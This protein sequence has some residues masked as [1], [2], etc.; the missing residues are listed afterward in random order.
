[1]TA[2]RVA[3]ERRSSALRSSARSRRRRRRETL[4]AGLFLSPALLI[5]GLFVVAPAVWAVYVSLT[6]YNLLGV[7]ANVHRFV[8]LANYRRLLD[9]P[10]FRGAIVRT[11]IFVF[12][13]AIVGQFVLG[14]AAA[15]IL[16][17]RD[18]RAR[19]LLGALIVLPLAVPEVVAGMMWA[20]ML[21][22]ERLGT[23]NRVLGVVGVGPIQWIANH[24]LLTIVVVN[25]W[26]GTA[27]AAI[28][29]GGALEAMPGD[30]VE[31]A[32]VDGATPRQL[33]RHVTVPLI[34]HAIT[35]YMLMTT[36]GTVTVFG[37]VF[38]L[39]QGGPGDQT[40]LLSI[41][42]YLKSFKF[43]EFG[44][45]AAASVLMFVLVLPLGAL[46]VRLLR[47]NV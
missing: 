20:S 29:F 8:G 14:L 25:I 43:F 47:A 27:F 2:L 34:S 23:L 17:R 11:A 5:L 41:F 24:A 21:E 37:L 46:Y 4:L 10:A 39:T 12:V 18:L 15:L 45:G 6:D 38:F 22:P 3:A 40:T 28:L 33:F 13:S 31:A 32:R 9:D 44:V 19:A 1:M 35:L 30:V 7:G 16:H 26:R 36:I 42:I